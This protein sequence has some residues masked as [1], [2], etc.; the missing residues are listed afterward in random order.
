MFIELGDDSGARG[1]RGVALPPSTP[2]ARIATAVTTPQH[3]AMSNAPTP[4][5]CGTLMTVNPYSP[6][7]LHGPWIG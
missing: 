3:Q 5:G 4:G 1:G 7:S 2:W 6:T